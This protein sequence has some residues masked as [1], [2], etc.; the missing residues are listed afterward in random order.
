[1]NPPGIHNNG[2]Q[3]TGTRP[4]FDDFQ[5]KSAIITGAASGIGLALAETLAARGADLA[6]ADIDARGLDAARARLESTGRR[7]FTR[8]LDVSSDV[9]VRDA[10]SEFE[11]ALGKIH[12]V[13]NNAGIDVSGE[14]AS[15]SESDWQRAFGV[16][17]FGVVHGIR[18]FLPLLRR[19]RE[20]AHIVNTASGA[21]FWVNGDF[22]MG[23]YSATKYCVVALSEALEQ[24]LSSSGIGVSVLCPGPVKTQIAEQSS[25]ASEQF[26]AGIA[27]GVAPELVAGLTLE[28]IRTNEFYIFTPTRMRPRVEQRF[29][30]ILDALGR[31]PTL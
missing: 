20:A 12:L 30:R 15:L 4:R 24:E 7:I 29:A 9:D 22:P 25:H 10:A 18:H 26:K 31:A 14:L 13:F 23:A 16:N 5:G 11:A 3:A 21:G 19:H 8:V 2:S 6:L 17:V 27:A 1:M 28:A